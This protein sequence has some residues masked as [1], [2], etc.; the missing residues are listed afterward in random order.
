M[1]KEYI[2]ADIGEEVRF[3]S[4]Y[5]IIQEERRI[6]YNGRELLV[7]ICHTILDNSCC[8]R[9]G[10]CYALVPGYI[11]SWKSHKNDKGVDVTEVDPV[12]DAGEQKTITMDLQSNEILQQVNF[13]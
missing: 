12:R 13:F 5:Y 2:H 3:I 6:K 8:G 10:C 4:G 7:V 9:T 11:V 1:N